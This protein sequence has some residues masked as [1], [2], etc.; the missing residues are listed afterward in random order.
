MQTFVGCGKE[1]TGHLGVAYVRE[2]HNKSFIALHSAVVQLA[3][4]HLY[5]KPL[6]GIYGKPVDDSLAEVV[7]RTVYIH[8]CLQTRTT[9]V[10][11]KRIG[12]VALRAADKNVPDQPQVHCCIRNTYIGVAYDTDQCTL[13]PMCTT[14]L[15]APLLCHQTCN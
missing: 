8:C 5:L 11:V 13:H 9:A 14:C 15:S 3:V 4:I 2:Q 12:S 10:T 6:A 7:E 1:V